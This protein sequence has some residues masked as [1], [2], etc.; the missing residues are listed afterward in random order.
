MQDLPNDAFVIDIDSPIR[1]PAM[2]IEEPTLA[3]ADLGY[4]TQ[5]QGY[6]PQQ[7]SGYETTS[8]EVRHS[9]L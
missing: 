1:A 8:S 2:L 7:Q 9:R 4:A 6:V 5:Q 3:A